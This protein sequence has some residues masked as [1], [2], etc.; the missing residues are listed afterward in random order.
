MVYSF[1]QLLLKI[2]GDA[3]FD[4]IAGLVLGQSE[5]FG[6]LGVQEHLAKQ[7]SYAIIRTKRVVFYC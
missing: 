1:N 4:H 5:R 6:H 3:K 7:L 2:R